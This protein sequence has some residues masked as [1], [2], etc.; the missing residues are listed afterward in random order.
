[1][2]QTLSLDNSFYRFIYSLAYSISSLKGSVDTLVYTVDSS[3]ASIVAS[4][5]SKHG[6]RIY[7]ISRRSS[8]YEGVVEELSLIHI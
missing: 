8:V 3:I 5:T 2:V 6:G 4:I 7:C 1:M